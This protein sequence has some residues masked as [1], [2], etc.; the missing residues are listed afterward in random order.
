MVHMKPFLPAET[1]CYG[2]KWMALIQALGPPLEAPKGIPFW[3]PNAC[4]TSG[5]LA[6]FTISMSPSGPARQPAGLNPG[7]GRGL[8]P[9][10][11]DDPHDLMSEP[12]KLVLPGVFL[13]WAHFG[14]SAPANRASHPIRRNSDPLN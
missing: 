2:K 8:R 1:K 13:L 7:L 6:F 14:T 4:F 10:L 9:S 11:R 12:V 5:F 3:L